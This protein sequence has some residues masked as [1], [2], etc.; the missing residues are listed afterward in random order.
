MNGKFSVTLEMI[1]RIQSMGMVTKDYL[2]LG[3]LFIETRQKS[4]MT[5]DYRQPR[6]V[7]WIRW[8]PK[9]S[10]MYLPGENRY[11]NTTFVINKNKEEL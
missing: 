1:L 11:V 2:F 6:N 7:N 10:W 8:N 4:I 9:R 3:I 5:N